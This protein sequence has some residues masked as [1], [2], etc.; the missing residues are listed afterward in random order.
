M[1][2]PR[3]DANQTENA[4]SSV[5]NPQPV[6]T[7]NALGMY[8]DQNDKQWYVAH[9][10]FDPATGTSQLVQRFLAGEDKYFASELF[11]IKTVELEMI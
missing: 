2:R 5:E 7:H 1:A 4:Q 9:F 6:L 3:K 11:R 10:Q 8:Q